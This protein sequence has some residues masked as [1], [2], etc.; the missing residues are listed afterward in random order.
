MTKLVAPIINYDSKIKM[1]HFGD[2]RN[3]L[4]RF[5]KP[6]LFCQMNAVY[7]DP[8]TKNQVLVVVW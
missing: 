3:P 6:G 1:S 5:R 2:G 7:K 8:G 4:L